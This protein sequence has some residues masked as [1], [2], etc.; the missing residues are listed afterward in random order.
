MPEA[1]A[2]GSLVVVLAFALLRPRGWPEALAAAPAAILL[3]ATGV[4]PWRDAV[5]ESQRLGPTL[6]FLA[7]VLLIADLA[8]R[9]GVFAA[10]GALLVGV[11]R[12]R[13]VVLLRSVFAVAAA[14]TV[15]LS[16]D[17]TVVLLTPVVFDAAATQQLPAKPHVYACAHLA[18]TASLLLPISNLTNLLA[19]SATGLSFG[20]FAALM[21]L[22]QLVAVGLE[23]AVLRRFFAADLV[24]AGS[25]GAATVRRPT[26]ALAVL[27]ITLLGFA[28]ASLVGAA[29][30][31]VAAGG[32]LLLA[33]RGRPRLAE[34]VRAA[35]PLFLLF[36][37]ALGLVVR[38]VSAHG[39]GRVVASAVPAG[40]TLLP[41]LAVAGL[42][43]LLANLLN[44]LPAVLLM[45]PAVAPHGAGPVLALLVG[46]NVGPNLSYVGSLAT[47]LW[48]R[49]VLSYGVE[50]SVP[51]FTRLGLL[52]APL[53]LVG[54]VTALWLSLGVFGAG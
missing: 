10:A 36:V 19:F 43:A 16:L 48:R 24:T 41:L 8:D 28:A 44:N 23:Y 33:L 45:L 18:N 15:V 2:V 26:Y 12:G 39:L 20:R 38:A 21:A 25:S 42:G 17:A 40:D 54:S 31:W 51:E 3:I 49:V 27:A 37:L 50:P 5:A 34:V 13:P 1:L 35:S 7:A 6:G 22:P 29:P 11:A 53:V 14:V 46:V 30:A 4:L 47:L 52:T 32:A 9:A